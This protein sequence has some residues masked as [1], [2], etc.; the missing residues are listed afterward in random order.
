MNGKKDTTSENAPDLG[1]FG[2]TRKD[3][4][5]Q[6]YAMKRIGAGPDAIH[7]WEPRYFVLSPGLMEWF[8]SH[9][10]NSRK[11]SVK[12]DQGGVSM[13][14]DREKFDEGKRRFVWGIGQNE[15]AN[16]TVIDAYNYSTQSKWLKAVEQQGCKNFGHI[17]GVKK[18]PSSV[19][20][21]WLVKKGAV[22]HTRYCVLLPQMLMYYKW[23]RD[24]QPQAVIPFFN[25]TEIRNGKEI[26]QFVI[27]DKNK[28]HEY[29]FKAYDKYLQ[30]EW[31]DSLKDSI[32]K[33]I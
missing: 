5:M 14:F 33:I 18:N 7:Y 26:N 8:S 21:G 15:K 16:P 30:K 19:R 13:T 2:D 27:V 6:G 20:E 22:W 23:K 3:I 25:N 12:L 24:K 9:Q 32:S 10:M 31:V 17:L 4:L 29:L 28:R 1:G 11:G